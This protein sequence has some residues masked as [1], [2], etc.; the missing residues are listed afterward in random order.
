MGGRSPQWAFSISIFGHISLLP[1]SP[2]QLH[3][4][5][6]PPPTFLLSLPS[7][8]AFDSVG[9]KLGTRILSLKA[10]I[11][12]RIF[13]KSLG[14]CWPGDGESYPAT[15]PSPCLPRTRQVALLQAVASPDALGTGSVRHTAPCLLEVIN[16][17]SLASTASSPNL[18]TARVLPLISSSIHWSPLVYNSPSRLRQRKLLLPADIERAAITGV[19][20]LVC[21]QTQSSQEPSSDPGTHSLLSNHP[22]VCFFLGCSC[23][24]LT[25]SLRN[26]SSYKDSHTD[27]NLCLLICIL[28]STH[29]SSVYPF[30]H[31]FH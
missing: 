12:H 31:Y 10:N 26:F 25:L 16:H 17:Q 19:W 4:R 14:S 21:L 28:A 2:P 20:Y 9:L 11:C 18:R 5:L 15:C 6:S 1:F 7:L 29:P 27:V 8:E 30:I 24:S 13:R 3:L 22:P 23:Q